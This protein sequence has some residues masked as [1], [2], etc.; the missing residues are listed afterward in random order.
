MSIKLAI[1]SRS[2][3]AQPGFNNPPARA[4]AVTMLE[5]IARQAAIAN[6]DIIIVG[7]EKPTDWNVP[8]TSFVP[9]LSDG[10]GSIGG[11]LA[12]LRCLEKSD[13]VILA[14]CDLQQIDSMSLLWLAGEWNETYD[15]L[16]L[17]DS[18]GRAQTLFSIYSPSLIPL[19]EANIAM[20]RYSILAATVEADTIEILSPS[21]LEAKLKDTN[22]IVEPPDHPSCQQESNIAPISATLTSVQVS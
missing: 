7:S 22:T 8:N 16:L 14:S 3:R 5:H 17:R 15:C 6:M 4:D 9:D 2:K 18:K 21:W 11:L 12:A 10:V 1:L 20:G 19:I 13:A